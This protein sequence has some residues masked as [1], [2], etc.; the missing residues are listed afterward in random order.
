MIGKIT[1]ILAAAALLASAGVA[2]AQTNRH[3]RVQWQAPY[4]NS[5]YNQIREIFALG[6]QTT[7]RL[8]PLPG[9]CLRCCSLLN[10]F[11]PHWFVFPCDSRDG[12][13]A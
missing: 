3:A 11:E 7:A 5:N 4:A 6:T 9:R 8:T 2:S 10:L 12:S 1:A 13:H